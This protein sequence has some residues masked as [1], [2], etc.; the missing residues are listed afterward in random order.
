MWEGKKSTTFHIF[1]EAMDKIQD[2]TGDNPH[3]I[4]RKALDNAM[5]QVEVKANVS[6]V[7]TSRFLPKS[8]LSAGYP[9]E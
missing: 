5:P 1:Y 2:K 9:L 3:D 6:E 8:V 4:W 7:P